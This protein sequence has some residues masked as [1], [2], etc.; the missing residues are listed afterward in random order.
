MSQQYQVLG[1]VAVVGKRSLE[2]RLSFSDCSVG[3]GRERGIG[4]MMIIKKSKAGGQTQT[5]AVSGTIDRRTKSK[6]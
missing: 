4:G 2:G 6:N 3:G 1:A 5:Q